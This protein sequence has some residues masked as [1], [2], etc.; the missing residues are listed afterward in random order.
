MKQINPIEL[1]DDLEDVKSLQLDLAEKVVFRSFPLP[2][3]VAAV[4]V[5]Y[6][7]DDIAH[8]AAIVMKVGTWD[9]I[10]EA[11]WSGQAPQRYS[12]GSFA[13]RESAP[14]IKALEGLK[15]R[16]SVLL[17]DGHGIAHPRR[18]G[19]ACHLGIVFDLPTVGCAKTLLC[20]Q[21]DSV[22]TKRSDVA[23]IRDRFGIIGKV[24]RTV[25]NVKPVYCSP[26]HKADLTSSA[27]LVLVSSEK[28]RIPTP[29]RA[30]HHAS[31]I[32]RAREEA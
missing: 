9:V 12:S 29:L 14:S 2:T 7:D 8:A 18:F 5:A 24:V 26:G 28:Y 21:T 19:L 6:C 13:S 23:D 15:D 3:T 22:G 11:Y 17:V 25:D 10:D 27:L 30:A 20:G 1:P 32:Q 31:I 16:P 4:D